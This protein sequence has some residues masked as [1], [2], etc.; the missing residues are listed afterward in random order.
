MRAQESKDLS[1]PGCPGHCEEPRITIIGP[2]GDNR[3]LVGSFVDLTCSIRFGSSRECRD[4]EATLGTRGAIAATTWMATVATQPALARDRCPRGDS[5]AAKRGFGGRL[6]WL[7]LASPVA[8]S[9]WPEAAGG[10]EPPIPS[11]HDKHVRGRAREGIQVSLRLT[12]ATAGQ[13][14]GAARCGRDRQ[15]RSAPKVS[16]VA[17]ANGAES[18]SQE[19]P[20]RL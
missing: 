14:C 5:A 16:L 17:P 1:L 9:C 7:S 20:Q 6:N 11:V 12:D 19:Q 10:R 8:R 2:R 15:R 4:G 13:P 18:T 3:P